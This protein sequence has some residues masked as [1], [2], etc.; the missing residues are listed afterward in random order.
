[1]CGCAQAKARV[2]AGPKAARRSDELAPAL[3]VLVGRAAAVRPQ[4]LV[5]LHLQP[6]RE[7]AQVPDERHRRRPAAA[8]GRSRRAP[9]SGSNQWKACPTVT[10]STLA[11]ASGSASAVPATTSAAGRDRCEHRAA[12]RR[13][14]RPR[15][16]GAPPHEQRRVSL[17]VPAA[18]S[19]TVRPGPSASRRRGTRSPPSRIAGPRTARTA[20]RRRRNAS[21]AIGCTPRAMRASRGRRRR[22]RRSRAARSSSERS[23]FTSPTSAVYQFFAS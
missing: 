20:R 8:R 22:R 5:Q 1:M 3:A 13:A 9:R 21:R 4:E 17:P 23:A 18:R 10:A 19:T 12:S 16:P 14:A 2:L 7:L 6:V 11:S 15:S